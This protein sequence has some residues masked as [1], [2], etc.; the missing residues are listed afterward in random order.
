[1]IRKCGDLRIW[2]EGEMEEREEKGK[3]ERPDYFQV[4]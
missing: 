1:V 2:T 4:S 3:G